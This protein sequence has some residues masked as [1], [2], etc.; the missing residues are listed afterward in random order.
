[1]AL[2]SSEKRNI[3]LIIGFQLIDMLI[4]SSLFSYKILT[5]GDSSRRSYCLAW[6]R[7]NFLFK[8]KSY[9]LEFNTS[10]AC[11]GNFSTCLQYSLRQ[12]SPPYLIPFIPANILHLGELLGSLH[13]KVNE[14]PTSTQ[15][16][17]DEKVGQDTEKSCQMDIFFFVTLLF[18]HYWFLD[19]WK[20]DVNNDG[21]E[22]SRNHCHRVPEPVFS[23]FP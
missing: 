9:I 11:I 6:K 15:T 17:D 7:D 12:R 5:I 19:V 23:I 1:M 2:L 22:T 18:I 4:K 16:A 8:N 10:A 21:P 20:R 3:F 14:V 13:H